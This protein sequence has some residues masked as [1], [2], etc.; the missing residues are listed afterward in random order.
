MAYYASGFTAFG[1]YKKIGGTNIEA[2]PIEPAAGATG[3][4][5]VDSAGDTANVPTTMAGAGF[6]IL[7][8]EAQGAE[9]AIP[10]LRVNRV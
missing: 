6:I 3:Q 4:I 9:L 8:G 2:K 10:V 5:D 7:E 1:A